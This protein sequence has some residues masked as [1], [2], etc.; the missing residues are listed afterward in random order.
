MESLN[1]VY[2]QAYSGQ[3]CVSQR[4]SSYRIFLRA[5]LRA[6][7]SAELHSLRIEVTDQ[8]PSLEELEFERHL[9]PLRRRFQLRMEQAYQNQVRHVE[10]ELQYY[11]FDAAQSKPNTSISAMRA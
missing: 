6:G 9:E 7:V 3:G 8:L 1:Q 11:P 5:H 2:F 4:Q 10:V